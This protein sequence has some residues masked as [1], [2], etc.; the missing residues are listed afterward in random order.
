[1]AILKLWHLPAQ[2]AQPLGVVN[3]NTRA[4]RTRSCGSS[5]SLREGTGTP[6]RGPCAP[7]HLSCRKASSRLSALPRGE[8]K[9]HI[10]APLPAKGGCLSPGLFCFTPTPAKPIRIYNRWLDTHPAD[11]PPMPARMALANAAGVTFSGLSWATW[12]EQLPSLQDQLE[13]NG[14]ASSSPHFDYQTG[15]IGTGGQASASQQLQA[16][17]LL[18]FDSA[19]KPQTASSL[20]SVATCSTPQSAGGRPAH[21]FFQ[22]SPPAPASRTVAQHAIEAL[23][24]TH[25]ERWATIMRLAGHWPAA[26]IAHAFS[27]KLRI[28]IFT[29]STIPAARA[30]AQ[31]TSAPTC[32]TDQLQR[33]LRTSRK[34]ISSIPAPI[35]CSPPSW[36]RADQDRHFDPYQCG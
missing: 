35:C 9:R 29:S 10:K 25:V 36:W 34:P 33:R 8:L 2:P 21:Q 20:Q 15:S 1:M 22:P 3:Q 16:P 19:R 13:A 6:R 30:S 17:R 31:S 12:S 7:G 5:T 14:L 18:S 4:K 11:W 32:A 28:W 27:P 24:L 23:Q 26:S